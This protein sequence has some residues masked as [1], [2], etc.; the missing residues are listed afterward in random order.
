M[1]SITFKVFINDQTRRFKSSVSDLTE[2]K[3]KL[4]EFLPSK[5][6][7]SLTWKDSDGDSI[8]ISTNDE[9]KEAVEEQSGSGTVKIWVTTSSSTPTPS[10]VTPSETE[11]EPEPEPRASSP[12]PPPPI[13]P[14]VHPHVECDKSDQSPLQGT[15]YH[16]VGANYDLNEEEF[17]KLD[18]A[19]KTQYELLLRPGG[20]IIR[21]EPVVHYG[22]TCDVSNVSPVFGVRFHKIGENYDLTQTEFAKLSEEEKRAYELINHPRATP[23]PY[24]VAPPPAQDD[25]NDE[26]TM[27]HLRS[28]LVRS[29]QVWFML[30]PKVNNDD[31]RET[32]K[33]KERVALA[34]NDS[35]N[36]N[37][38]NDNSDTND[39]VVSLLAMFSQL[40]NSVLGLSDPV[41]NSCNGF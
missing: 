1:S 26:L 37:V 23:V 33:E 35:N 28:L 4:V 3:S 30:K 15:R 34:L 8:T 18:D 13:V 36:A 10:S 21:W 12:P 5:D 24:Y 16:K 9:F 41:L 17:A 31:V 29:F 32:E 14:V 22:V 20:P 6:D 25:D 39:Q 40:P 19:E 2:F 38:H 11:K 7:A 27:Q